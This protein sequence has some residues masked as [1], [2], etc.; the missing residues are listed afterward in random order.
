MAAPYAF[1]SCSAGATAPP[2]CPDFWRRTLRSAR[3]AVNRCAAGRASTQTAEYLTPRPLQACSSQQ[4]M[5]VHC[6][7]RR[8]ASSKERGSPC[9]PST[10]LAFTSQPGVP[11]TST[12]GF[13]HRATYIV[14]STI[15]K[16]ATRAEIADSQ[17]KLAEAICRQAAALPA[18]ACAQIL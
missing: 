13:D 7:C 9:R 1:Q 15:P 17:S 2:V 3:A 16:L 10:T 4:R 18:C 11:Y 12:R 14:H 8:D 6:T 5:H